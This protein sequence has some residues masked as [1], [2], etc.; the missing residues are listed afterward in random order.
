MY[1]DSL[2][3]MFERIEEFANEQLDMQIQ[4]DLLILNHKTVNKYWT[5]IKQQLRKNRHIN[6]EQKTKFKK[7]GKHLKLA[8]AMTTPSPKN[9]V[10]IHFNLHFYNSS[11]F[12]YS[13]IVDEYDIFNKYMN[14]PKKSERV[15]SK[16]NRGPYVNIT[17][18]GLSL[19]QR[20]GGGH[21]FK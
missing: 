2:Y 16:I 10:K 21:T 8:L 18:P 17:I 1:L 6:E 20:K 3:D 12:T 4:K 9:S 19:A 13:T 7:I 14:A 11:Y 5:K 15:K